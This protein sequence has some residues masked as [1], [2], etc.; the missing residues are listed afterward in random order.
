[1]TERD[2]SRIV[3]RTGGLG[4]LL[5]FAG[6]AVG[7]AIAGLLFAPRSGAETRARVR[8]L[9]DRAKAK[10]SRLPAAIHEARGA[11]RDAFNGGMRSHVPH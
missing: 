9:A 10:V 3:V 11:A 6:G 5:A 8:D 4:R 2:G 1:M 7:G